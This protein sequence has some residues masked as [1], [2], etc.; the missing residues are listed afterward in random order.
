MKELKEKDRLFIEMYL[1]NGRNI[2]KAY[3]DCG[4]K[5]KSG[6]ASRFFH[7]EHIQ[8]AIKEREKEIR[9]TYKFEREEILFKLKDTYEAF[10]TL[11][12]LSKQD[13]TEISTSDDIKFSRMASIIKASD[14]LKAKEM[15]M[16]YLGF[17]TPTQGENEEIEEINVRIIRKGDNK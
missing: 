6:N 15:L 1:S 10:H 12:E 11:L 16:R 3:E 9:D 8:K 5:S 7:Q 17:D 4:Y 2:T 13:S 14:A